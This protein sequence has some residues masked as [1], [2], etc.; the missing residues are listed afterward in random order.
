MKV[1]L[2]ILLCGVC[3]LPHAHTQDIKTNNGQSITQAAL[4][5]LVQQ[6]MQIHHMAGLSLAVINDEKVVFNQQYGYSNW[7]KQKPVESTTLF[8]GASMTKPVFAFLVMRLVEQGV[9][10][11]DKPL[12]QYWPNPD[13]VHDE[14]Y[15]LITARMVLTHSTGLPNW[16]RGN[17]LN[18]QFDPGTNFMYSGEA[19]VFLGKVLLHLTQRSL[20]ELAQKEIFEPFDMTQTTLVWSPA[21]SPMKATGHYNGNVVSV[22]HSRPRKANPAAS[23]HTTVDDFSKFM[24]AM[25]QGKGLKTETYA[26]MFK[27]QYK[28]PLGHNNQNATGSIAWGLGWVL[29]ETPF[30]LKL[31]HGGNNGD[32]TSYFELSQDKKIGYV[33]FTNSDRANAFNAVLKPYLTIGQIPNI[34]AKGLKSA[35]QLDF[36]TDN[37]TFN[38]PHELGTFNGRD[39]LYSEGN[40]EAIVKGK[41]FKNMIIEFDISMERGYAFAGLK[42]RQKDNDN[43]ESLILRSIE[44][45]NDHAMQ[46]NPVFNGSECWQLYYGNN[47]SRM[48]F[49]RDGEWMH[50]KLAI[51]DDRMEVLIDDMDKLTLNVYDLKHAIEPGTVALWSD[52]PVYFANF[53]IKEIESYDFSQDDQPKPEPPVGTITQW[54]VSEP[55]TA[56]KEN[57]INYISSQDWTLQSCESNGLVNFARIHTF[58]NSQNTVL[59]K[60]IILS[61]KN[62]RKRLQFG[63]SDVG[64]IYLNQNMLY[65]GQRIYRSRDDA[66]YGTIGY[67]DNLYLDLQKGANEIWFVVSEN[68][69]G[70]GLMAK[71]DDLE[72]IEIK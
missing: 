10:E 25:M 54:K 67:Y 18:L 55:F 20:E 19:F 45:G 72:G 12:Y 71:F 8:E 62:Q 32:F 29:E 51:Y 46:Y 36:T 27:V 22:D 64:A 53:R 43:Y 14:R 70:W 15:Q 23:I 21:I 33:F 30:G 1:L 5:Q 37:F 11:L 68:F 40:T 17:K 50:V 9:L 65:E 6:Q 3:W 59:A 31:Q 7:A 28:L 35:H 47:Y 61:D 24:I 34:P 57:I 38:G 42:F 4:N 58:T 13:L 63:Y 39:C 2:A 41:T 44:S 56:G 66:Y 69:G 52:M 16:A 48:A 26:E 60:C 49:F